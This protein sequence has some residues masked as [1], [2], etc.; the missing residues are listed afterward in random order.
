MPSPDLSGYVDL[1]LFDKN[2]QDIY[3]AAIAELLTRV[4]EFVPVEGSIEVELLEALALQVAEAAYAINRVPG[5]VAQIIM[6]LFGITM[7]TG[8]Q[9]TA[10]ITFTLSDNLGHVVP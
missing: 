8:T 4:P 7:F 5:A 1:S 6:Q 3:D 9:P 10:D 2:P